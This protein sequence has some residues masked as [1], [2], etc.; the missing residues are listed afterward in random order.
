M[1][2]T[3]HRYQIASQHCEFAGIIVPG[4]WE[5][6]F[7]FVGDPYK[8]PL[9]PT[10]DK[11]DPLEVLIPRMIRAAENYDVIPVPDKPHYDVQSW[12]GTETKL[13]G[14]FGKG[15]YFLKDGQGDKFILDGFIARP[16]ATLRE[17]NG[18]FSTYD[19]QASSHFASHDNTNEM[20]FADAHHAIIGTRGEWEVTVDGNTGRIAAGE[21][22]FIPA[23][24]SWSWLPTSAYSRAYVF[25]NKEGFGGLITASGKP[26]VGLVMPE[27]NEFEKGVG[28]VSK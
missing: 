8:G 25:S 26:Y 23:G 22:A 6:F 17:S 2:G 12:D 11:R 7:R 10:E 15:G 19:I 27:L 4:G 24:C 28:Y 13:P 20:V 1:Q 16:L 18:K 9:F 5:N 3:I 21:T 14:K